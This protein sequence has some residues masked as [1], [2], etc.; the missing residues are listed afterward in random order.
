MQ[1]VVMDRGDIEMTARDNKGKKG[2]GRERR[3]KKKGV[4]EKHRRHTCGDVCAG[5]NL[6]KTDGGR[7]SIPSSSKALTGQPGHDLASNLLALPNEERHPSGTRPST[8]SSLET[9]TSQ[10]GKKFS[11]PTHMPNAIRRR[12]SGHPCRSLSYPLPPPSPPP[13]ASKQ[14]DSASQAPRPGTESPGRH[15]RHRS[16]RRRDLFNHLKTDHAQPCRS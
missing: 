12:A 5:I 1:M 16:F 15:V 4:R 9:P 8:P 7:P 10:P 2:R 14:S 11:P 6:E 3:E 13:A